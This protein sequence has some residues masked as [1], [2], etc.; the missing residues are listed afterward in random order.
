MP[1][2]LAHRHDAFFK[3]FMSRPELART[4]LREHLPPQIAQLLAPELP[5][6]VPGSYVDEEL[7]Q[8]HSDLVFRVHLKSGDTA[9]AYIL[10][11]HK[12]S[13]DRATRLQLLR[14]IVRILTEWD[15]EN[16][17]LPLPVVVPL[18]AHQGP[19]GWTC[20][21]E[22]TDL[23]GDVPQALRPYL[24]SF[25]HAL[26]DL[27]AIEDG[28]LSA[29]IRLAAYLNAMKYAQRADLPEHLQIIL[30]PELTDADMIAI[31]HYL[32]TGPVAV[33]SQRIQAALKPLNPNRRE[34][35]MGHFSEEFVKQGRAEGEARGEANALVRLLEKRFG[36][37]SRSLR[38]RI[39]ASDI[40][41]IKAWFDR[42]IE[43]RELQSVFE[44]KVAA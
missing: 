28:A 35:I 23:F 6:Q 2:P 19:Q 14:Y 5:E 4:F 16:D 22:F 40:V 20:S 29:D 31:L 41:T 30:A 43:A 7:A 42:A 8:H 17:A 21:A 38:D 44:P 9:V 33:G 39:F 11:E 13:P 32:N 3:Q 34:E 24:V 27:A 12:S 37:I 10:I 15:A 26:V 36:G 1:N 25:R 18:V